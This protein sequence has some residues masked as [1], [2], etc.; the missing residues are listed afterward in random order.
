MKIQSIVYKFLSVYS[1]LT[2]IALFNPLQG[3]ETASLQQ[4]DSL[5]A[6]QRYSRAYQNYEQLLEEGVAS[7]AML[8]RMAYIQESFGNVPRT[9]YLLNLYYNL[10]A[11]REVLRKIEKLAESRN[12][13]GYEYSDKEYFMG[14]ARQYR[15]Q[16][17]AGIMLL[18][19][20]LFLWMLYRKVR[21]KEK[22]IWSGL[23]LVLLLGGLFY[24][25]KLPMDGRNAIVVQDY[26]R[27]MRG[28]SSGAGVVETI[29]RGHRLKVL[30]REDV[31]LRVEWNDQ[32][33][34]VKETAITNV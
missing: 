6:Q 32:V 13:K 22:P 25:I 7:P 33:L 10:T 34:Y 16:I 23:L 4:A 9:L 1:I 28:P 3:Q 2:L 24:F 31:W 11:D 19:G 21:L 8:L 30:G 14:T 29:G 15:S 5:F 26:V 27:L 17:I 18:A 20:F 12:L